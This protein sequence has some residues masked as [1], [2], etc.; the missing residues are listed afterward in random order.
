[1]EKVSNAAAYDY[2]WHSCDVHPA[3]S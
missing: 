3:S 1:V 2:T